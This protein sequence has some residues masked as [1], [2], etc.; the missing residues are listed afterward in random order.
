VKSLFSALTPIVKL[1]QLIP[2]D[3][4]LGAIFVLSL[5][6]VGMVLETLGIGLVIPMLALMTQ[7]DIGSR[8]PQI[9]PVLDWLGN[10]P[11]ERLVVIATLTLVGAYFVKTTF[12]GFLA[13]K[14]ARFVYQMQATLSQSLFAR[15][16][17]QPYSFHLQR[18]SSELIN[19]AIMQVDQL[20]AGISNGLTLITEL[21]VFAGISALLLAIEP[22]GA[23][24]VVAILGLAALAFNQITRSHILRWGESGRLHNSLR[25]KHLQQG[26][27]SAKDVKL[28]GREA[29]FIAQY[30]YHSS[31]Y[32]KANEYWVTLTALPRLWLELLAISGLATLII[33]VINQNKPLDSLLPV[34]G[35]FATAAFRLMPSVSRILSS[36]HSVRFYTPMIDNIHNELHKLQDLRIPGKTAVIPFSGALVLDQVTFRYPASDRNAISNVSFAVPK[37]ASVGFI[38]ESGAGKSSLVDV[39]LG[40]LHPTGGTIRVDGADIRDNLRAWQDQIG[41]VPQSIYLTDDSIRRNVAFGLPPEAIDEEAIWRAIRDARLEEFIRALPEGLDT[42]VGERGIRISGGQRQRIGIA[43]ALYHDPAVLV[44]DEATSALDTTTEQGVMEAV[45]KLHGRKT[46]IIVAHR[47]STVEH[48]DHILRFENGRLVGNHQPDQLKPPEMG[49]MN[50]TGECS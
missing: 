35:V 37:G 46:I 25:I 50:K 4:H 2:P 3:K 47:M 5:S 39:I 26:L 48:C 28:L 6:L 31:G 27:G 11:Q 23:S 10:P 40:L 9:R 17:R 13:W 21:A 36:A 24:M 43:R 22:L 12:L 44:L 14:Q 41:Y 45:R 29:D 34:I 19:N 18:N 15:Y 42:V 1:W 20:T 16:L 49:S 7:G 32:A 30:R 33:V 8:Y 38:G